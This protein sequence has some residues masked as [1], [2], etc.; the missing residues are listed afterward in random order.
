MNNEPKRRPDGRY[1]IWVRVAKGPKG[2]V[3]AFGRTPQAARERAL[4]LRQAYMEAA[5]NSP[6]PL[7]T[8]PI[9][10]F[11]EF[12]YKV[13]TPHV[14]PEIRLSTEAKYN[15][16]VVH[17]LLPALADARMAE[18]GYDEALYL[19]NSIRRHDGRPGEPS[20]AHVAEVVY[21]FR[22]IMGLYHALEGAKG[23]FV[24]RDWALVDA[25]AKP[26]KKK[27][28]T[29]PEG[30]IVSLLKVATPAERGAV[31]G[32]GVLALRRGEFCGLLKSRIDRRA[33]LLTVDQQRSIFTGASPAPTKRDPR[34]L[35][36]TP[37]LLAKIDE[38]ADPR[39]V[40]V[41]TDE[42]G[43][44]WSPDHL[45]KRIP[46]LCYRATIAKVEAHLG[47]EL[48]PEIKVAVLSHD[49]P[50]DI[51]MDLLRT[52]AEEAGLVPEDVIVK[53]SGP[54]DLRSYAASNLSML[55]CDLG[56]IMEILGH[57]ELDTTMIYVNSRDAEKRD[58][59]D[60]LLTRWPRAEDFQSSIPEEVAEAA[61]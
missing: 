45:T 12:V 49:T 20:N 10:S 42:Q 40:Y 44:P 2:R 8:W 29:P 33:M 35:P 27:R 32:L 7:P 24:R 13:W 21:R 30:F 39:S 19:R 9:G 58:A 55:G 48:P 28:V 56:T 54:H 15:A 16:I 51:Q 17:H 4:E 31:F 3:P 38:F 61:L 6:T 52:A 5:E 59:L 26:K 1:L 43:R 14:Y 41:F 34:V 50:V 60:Q 22:E 11:A 25:P 23:R 57:T 53:R 37:A 18:I 47:H 46:Q 36:L